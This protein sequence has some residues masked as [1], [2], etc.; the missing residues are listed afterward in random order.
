MVCLVGEQPVPNLLPIRHCQ[1]QQ[2]VLVHSELTK[3]VSDNLE[4]LLGRQ[5]SVLSHK[6]PPYD[7]IGAQK[8]LA[9]YLSQADWQGAA[10]LLNLTGGTKP[11][12]LAA[13]RLAEQWKAPIVYL[14]SEGG[15]SQLYRYEFDNNEIVLRERAIIGE[16]LTI[17]DYL[18]VH[19]LGNYGRRRQTEPFQQLVF[20]ALQPHVSEIISSVSLGALEIDLM[21]RCG[22]QVGVA[23]VKSRKAAERKNGIDQLN[24]ASQREFL[25]TYTKRFLIL[26]RQLGTN[27]RELAQAH[28][29]IVIELLGDSSG[30]LSEENR[31][32]LIETVTRVLGGKP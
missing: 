29:I 32:R 28:N 9:E 26:D 16:L 22:N 23:E 30:S 3:R 1:P 20:Q 8:S 14:Q 7:L 27:N 11:M 17:T 31:K 5:V 4:Q 2:V 13:F 12:S 25:G 6:V 10:F 18:K 21:I 24:T 15:Q 19:A